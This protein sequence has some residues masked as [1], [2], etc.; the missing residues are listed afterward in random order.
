MHTGRCLCGAVHF[1]ASDVESQYHACH[2]G[3]CR[4]WGGSPMFA[5]PAE[6]VAFSGTENLARYES[7]Q[8]AE[9]GFCRLCGSHL[10]YYLAPAEQYFMAVGTFDDPTPFALSREIFVDHKPADYSFA[11]D[12]ERWTEAQTLAHFS[13]N[14]E[15]G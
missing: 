7:S 9:R 13:S 10:F 5:V 4:R 14:D 8:W 15:D 2:C 1:S 3:M 11:G 12:L 6:S